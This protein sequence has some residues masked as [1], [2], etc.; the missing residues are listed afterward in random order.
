MSGKKPPSRP[1]WVKNTYFWIAGILL[2]LAIVGFIQ[3]DGTIRDPGQKPES[4]LALLYLGASVL[5]LLGG[6]MSHTQTIQQ[7]EEEL[8][9]RATKGESVEPARPTEPAQPKEG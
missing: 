7:Y 8:Q 4:N 5:M 2:V 3:G 9:M 1:A 6:Y